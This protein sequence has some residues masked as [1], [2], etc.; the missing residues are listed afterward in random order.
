[1]HEDMCGNSEALTPIIP[2][3]ER[4]GF[5]ESYAPATVVK[6]VVSALNK[7]TMLLCDAAEEF[8]Q[9]MGGNPNILEAEVAG[10]NLA[11][12][13]QKA[14]LEVET[15]SVTIAAMEK[16]CLEGVTTHYK[17]IHARNGVHKVL[18]NLVAPHTS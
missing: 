1:M 10:A 17:T 11:V 4:E 14:L 8:T 5:V 18:S 7:A 15:Q 2:D 3:V 13:C 12:A 16:G 9:V 6:E